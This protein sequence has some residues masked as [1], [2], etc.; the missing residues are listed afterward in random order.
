ME[1]WYIITFGSLRFPSFTSRFHFQRMCRTSRSNREPRPGTI[2]QKKK[3]NKTDD[4]P[5][6]PNMVSQSHC[7]THFWFC[8]STRW[9][10][11][12][13]E[14]PGDQSFW[15]FSKAIGPSTL[16]PTPTDKEGERK[17][18]KKNGT[19]LGNVYRTAVSFHTL[20]WHGSWFR[21]M[22][23]T[24]HVHYSTTDRTQLFL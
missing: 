18:K 11:D 19:G 16:T 24:L 14:A 10:S 22:L 2:N 21:W 9:F 17:E 7:S 13:A 5:D 20:T 15:R 1:F 4:F 8:F 23:Y 3:K 12:S 6:F